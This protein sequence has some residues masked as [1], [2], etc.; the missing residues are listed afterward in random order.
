MTRSPSEVIYGPV[1]S[2]RSYALAQL[3]KYSFRVADDATKPAIARAL[4]EHYESQ[5]IKVVAVNTMRVH[6]K[7][8]RLGMRGAPGRTASWKKAVVTLG[9]GQSLPELFGAV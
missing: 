4:E 7:R 6:G 8:K 2:E 5:G 3:G 1:I 9:P